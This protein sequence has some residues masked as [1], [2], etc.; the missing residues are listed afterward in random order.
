VLCSCCSV[1]GHSDI[2]SAVRSS[3]YF[4]LLPPLPAECPEID[5]DISSLPII[6]ED[7]YIEPSVA[8]AAVV[9]P[10][11]SSVIASEFN[12]NDSFRVPL[13]RTSPGAG[14]SN[15]GYRSSVCSTTSTAS[16]SSSVRGGRKSGKHKFIKN[17]RPESFRRPSSMINQ[18]AMVEGQVATDQ[19]DCT[20]VGYRKLQLPG[21][22]PVELGT[23]SSPTADE[24][25]NTAVSFNETVKKESFDR[26]KV[27]S[28][29]APTVVGQH[30]LLFNALSLPT[31]YPSGL[32]HD[33]MMGTM[34]ATGSMPTLTTESTVNNNDLRPYW[35]CDT[36][37]LSG[38]AMLSNNNEQSSVLVDT[39]DITLC[40][41]TELSGLDA[42]LVYDAC[43]ND[44]YTA[45]VSTMV[46]HVKTADSYPVES[47]NI[48]SRGSVDSSADVENI[49]DRSSTNP[50]NESSPSTSGHLDDTNSSTGNCSRFYRV[51]QLGEDSGT[52]SQSEISAKST[53]NHSTTSLT[54]IDS[55]SREVVRDAE[56]TGTSDRHATL[57]NTEE[58]DDLDF[59]MPV[60]NEQYLMVDENESSIVG[61][62]RN[63]RGHVPSS[64]LRLDSNKQ[65]VSGSTPFFELEKNIDQKSG[66]SCELTAIGERLSQEAG[67]A[68]GSNTDIAMIGE[69]LSLAGSMKGSDIEI[70]MI[71]ERLSL[72]GSVKGNNADIAMVGERLSLAGSA[73]GSNAEIAMI[74]ERLSRSVHVSDPLIHD[75]YMSEQCT[76]LELIKEEKDQRKRMAEL[77]N[78]GERLCA[79]GDMRVEPDYPINGVT[80]PDDSP[81]NSDDEVSDSTGLSA[82]QSARRLVQVVRDETVRFIRAKEVLRKQLNYAGHLYR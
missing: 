4:Q 10:T 61:E 28:E 67:N 70:A 27:E 69:R 33:G 79:A 19:K 51:D 72:A 74:G 56:Q 62:R 59:L 82:D 15:R 3:S 75:Q 17:I 31:L 40:E 54:F 41:T 35:R 71:G 63:E 43:G 48:C 25:V 76:I 57:T 36:T 53:D 52:G 32:K 8:A 73:K 64:T 30:S 58:F 9:A 45:A 65:C 44:V 42:T 21:T 6:F 5:G 49:I 29:V 1:H 55:S 39:N 60:G 13:R 38:D 78:I 23:L 77:S 26:P 24:S 2:A 22:K 46:N 68:T 11:V 81:S 66:S 80:L 14:A 20:L 34:S 7:K 16:D 47:M 50:S 12:R 18:Q 37:S